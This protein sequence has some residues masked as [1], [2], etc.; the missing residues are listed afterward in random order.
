VTGVFVNR[1]VPVPS[2]KSSTNACIALMYVMVFL[3][4]HDLIVHC[5][6]HVKVGSDTTVGNTRESEQWH[7]K[8]RSRKAKRVGAGVG[9]RVRVSVRVRVTVRGRVRHIMRV[10]V[11][12]RVRG[13]SAS[14]ARTAAS[15]TSES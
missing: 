8:Q 5:G 14:V 1:S 3:C 9:V 13:E 11:S 12:V 10:R 15:T 6:P 7:A 4:C 2:F